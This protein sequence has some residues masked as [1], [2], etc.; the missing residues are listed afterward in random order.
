MSTIGPTFGD[1]VLAAGL[2]GLP[3]S[4]GGDGKIE[5]RENLSP[6]QN[7]ALDAVIAAHDSNLQRK[8]SIAISAFLGRWTLTEYKA[9]LQGRAAAIAA[10]GTANM[11]LVRQ[12]DQAM[13][14]GQVDLNIPAAQTFKAALVSAGILTQAR[15]DVIFA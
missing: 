15:A 4:W 7:A 8:N 13:S 12:W 1:E 3:F 2:G 9:L 5:G 11:A 14:L 10:A 6:A